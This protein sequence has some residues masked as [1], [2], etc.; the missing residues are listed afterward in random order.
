M[1][2]AP[3]VQIVDMILNEP[4]VTAVDR[5]RARAAQALQGADGFALLDFVEALRLR[6]AGIDKPIVDG[7]KGFSA[8]I[9][10][11]CLR[12]SFSERC[13]NP[14]TR[15]KSIEIDWFRLPTRC[16]SSATSRATRSAWFA[17]FI[18]SS[19]KGSSSSLAC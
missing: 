3:A 14:S 8:G 16:R 11:R 5:A 6:N 1:V 10:P 4:A 12:S 9:S 19:S 15:S 13:S 17:A 7:E 2:A 18:R